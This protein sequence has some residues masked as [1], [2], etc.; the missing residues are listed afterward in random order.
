MSFDRVWHP[1]PSRLVVLAVNAKTSPEGWSSLST[2]EKV[3]L[4]GLFW[5]VTEKCELGVCRG[6]GAFSLAQTFTLG[7][8]EQT[9]YLNLL[10]EVSLGF[11]LAGYPIE[12]EEKL[13]MKKKPMNGLKECSCLYFPGVNAWAREKRGRRCRSAGACQ[14]QPLSLLFTVSL[15]IRPSALLPARLVIAA[16]ITAPRSFI[17]VAL[18]SLI[19]SLTACSISA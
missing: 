13:K 9:I 7:E 2:I 18:V 4:E 11:A 10:Q 3:S 8:M 15:T 17:E 16:F 6:D 5:L 12:D 1:K 19:A 14:I